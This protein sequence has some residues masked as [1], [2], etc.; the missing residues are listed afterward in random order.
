MDTNKY[1]KLAKGYFF[2]SEF[3]MKNE[4]DIKKIIKYKKLELENLLKSKNKTKIKESIKYFIKFYENNNIPNKTKEIKKLKL[5]L[6][7]NLK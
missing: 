5:K 4:F 1:L 6:K 7:E 3:I 2:I